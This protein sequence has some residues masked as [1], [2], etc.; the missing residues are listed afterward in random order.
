MRLHRSSFTRTLITLVTSACMGGTG[1][2]LIGVNGGGDGGGTIGQARVLQFF[3]Q[4]SSAN[5]G[6]V[7]PTV[8]VMARDSIG[9]VDSLFRGQVSLSLQGTGGGAL[10]GTQNAAAIRGIASFGNLRI[11]VPGTYRLRAS[12]SGATAVTSDPFI[13]TAVTT[14]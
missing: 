14:P 3:S 1:S 6:Q 12:A 4:P 10:N 2:G 7:M 9:N 8:Q 11:D 13:I 5:A